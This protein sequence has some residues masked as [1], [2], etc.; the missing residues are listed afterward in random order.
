LVFLAERPSVWTL[1]GGALI[2]GGA[3]VVVLFGSAEEGLA[4]SPEEAVGEADASS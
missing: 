2:L 1:L 3:V 4:G